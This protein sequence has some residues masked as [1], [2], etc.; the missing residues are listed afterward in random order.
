M[1]HSSK[2]TALDRI[3]EKKILRVGT[4]GD[5]KPFSF[6]KPNGEYEGIDIELARDL[7]KSLGAEIQFIPTS[8]VTLIQDLKD[9]KFD[10]AMGGISKNLEREKVGLFSSGYF[11]SGKTPIAR[12]EDKTRFISLDQIDNESVKIIVNP[13]G[14]N[15]KFVKEHITKAKII[16]HSDVKTIFDQIVSGKADVMI[17]DSVEVDFITHEQPTLCATMPG[18]TFDQFEKAYLMQRDLIFKE[19]VDTWLEQLKLDGK[20]IAAFSRYLNVK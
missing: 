8:W 3:L 6:L 16:T 11:V 4:T 7:G 2:I 10:I 12:C 18:K 14:T 9:K 19:Y 17:T 1:N 20:I 13:G 5:Y 15:A